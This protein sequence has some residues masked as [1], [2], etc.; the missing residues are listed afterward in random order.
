MTTRGRPRKPK[1]AGNRRSIS[2]STQ[3]IKD[4][5]RL[6]ETAKVLEVEELS[7]FAAVIRYAW[8]YGGKKAV[9]RKLTKVEIA[10]GPTVVAW[11]DA[12]G[13]EVVEREMHTEIL[14]GDND[15]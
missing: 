6:V 15:V 8:R 1:D 2:M 10:R 14:T 13:R 7:S 5:Q 3:M 4:I 12:L 9:V 11:G